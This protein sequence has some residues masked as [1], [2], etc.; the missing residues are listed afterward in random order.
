LFGDWQQP[1]TTTQRASAPQSSFVLHSFVLGHE[2]PVKSTHAFL[3]LVEVTQKHAP[4]ESFMHRDSS[5][6]FSHASGLPRQ[7]PLLLLPAAVPSAEA[8]PSL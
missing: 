3:P 1:E 4:P 8:R 2:R 6:K 5:E 7:T